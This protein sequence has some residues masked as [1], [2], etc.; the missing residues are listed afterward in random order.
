M[1]NGILLKGYRSYSTFTADP[2]HAVHRLGGESEATMK[3]DK[4]P[5][6]SRLL[7]WLLMTLLLLGMLPLP[8]FA[9]EPPTVDL[10]TGPIADDF[11]KNH[12]TT[13][14][15]ICHNASWHSGYSLF[16][17][18]AGTYLVYKLQIPAG[19]NVT[20]IVDFKNWTGVGNGGVH[21]YSAKPKV[22]WYVTEDAI[23]TNFNGNISSWEK[24]DANETVSLS[25]YTYSYTLT[26]NTDNQERTVYACMK[27]SDNDNSHNGKQGWNDGAWVDKITFTTEDA[28]ALPEPP[29]P[30]DPLGGETVNL[31]DNI[32]L[33]DA[34]KSQKN[35][36]LDVIE[37]GHWV[38]TY[39][40][41]DLGV[42]QYILYRITLPAQDGVQVTMDYKNW[43]TVGNGGVHQYSSK[44]KTAW[45][46][47]DQAPGANFNGNVS[48]WTR[49]DANEELDLDTFTYTH[50]L[51]NKGDDMEARTI[52][53]C[54]AFVSN[55]A[56]YH[57]QAGGNDGAWIDG[58][59]FD[60]IVN[61]EVA[62]SGV[63]LP[64][65]TLTLA[66]GKTT[67]LQATLQP[68]NATVRNLLWSSSEPT[69]VSVD[70]NGNVTA[71]G[72]GSAIITVSTADGGFEAKCTVTVP[73]EVTDIKLSTDKAFDTK[74]T[75]KNSAD[76]DFLPYAWYTSQGNGS[77]STAIV[78]WDK[79]T[80]RDLNNNAFAIYKLL[81]PGGTNAQIHLDMV[82]NYTDGNGTHNGV[83][84]SGMP[85]MNV[86]YTADD[87]T[88]ATMDDA[89]WTRA[90]SDDAWKADKDQ[91]T[92][93][94]SS[95]EAEDRY[96]YVKIYSTHVASQGA[97]IEQLSFDTIIPEATE[98][99]IKAPS[100]TEYTVGQTLSLRG[101]VVGVR[102]SDG[103]EAI[104][105]ANEYTVDHSG[106]LT[107]NDTLITVKTA[108][109]KL[110]GTFSLVILEDD[111][112]NGGCGSVL[113]PMA[114]T[115]T[116]GAA[117]ATVLLRRK[118]KDKN[119]RR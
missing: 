11:L 25:T 18:G 62:V 93:T 46:V 43:T 61:Q 49:I 113:S 28:P 76:A 106:A 111:G 30:N 41:Y 84:S 101:M 19:E 96:V 37:T 23:D 3:N 65:S 13:Q 103:S 40:L 51:A 63:T 107:K 80:F 70:K 54:L 12:G 68:A 87:I 82:T 21:Q 53:A 115:L 39:T 52:Y 7:A 100:R 33:T 119:E 60:R 1:Y 58:I 16:D 69:I 105:S 109:G 83:V 59:T 48:G 45:Y 9:A 116:L 98:L 112:T 42:N 56:Q 36:L 57:G 89:L 38:D 29:A 15:Y 67:K 102:Y 86:F 90:D 26:N 64:E 78:N 118:R 99:W 14:S 92:F 55:D 114:G 81:V 32:T 71:M 27:F 95:M 97:W 77:N 8:A 5:S 2:H 22:Q 91:Y 85:R 73:D 110:S 79:I 20:A 74:I 44:P 75:A 94:V 50:T 66:F 88:L 24:I 10:L 31:V 117:A 47:T 72:V 4:H 17:V 34:L 6:L 35:A 104:L 108:D